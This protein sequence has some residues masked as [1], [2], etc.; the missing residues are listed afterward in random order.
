MDA[1]EAVSSAGVSAVLEIQGLQKTY[2]TLLRGQRVALDGLDMVVERGDVHG[3][4]GPNGSGKST[5]LKILL[6]LVQ[7]DGGHMR[8]LGEPVPARLAA[9][10]PKVGAIVESP[11]FFKNFSGRRTLR[12]LAQAGG[13]P[14]ERVEAALEQVGMRARAGDRVKSYSLGMRQRLAVAS[15]LLKSP[16][17][18]I[19]D[20]PANGLDPA[21]IREMRDLL[22]SLA[23][24]GTTVIIS[25]H[26]LA[27]IQQ[28]CDS[29]TIISRGRRVASGA[30][31][32]VLAASDDRGEY[33]VRVK[34]LQKAAGIIA[35]SG[36]PVTVAADHF[37]VGDL[38][39]PAWITET[40]AAHQLW[41]SEL[42]P[43]AD[44]EDAFL[45][46]TGTAPQRGTFRQ[47]DDADWGK[48]APNQ[49]V[50]ADIEVDKA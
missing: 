45:R 39:D 15:A 44:L 10:A 12:L 5:T 43:L 35:E 20:E 2:Q 9:V 26:I 8:M 18:L 3:F 7:A 46:L 22:R 47:V 40:L 4:L 32:D 6:G 17:L 30:V 21:G 25:S 11:E 42:T 13:V 23:D 31:A 49:P 33:K 50:P 27:E 19:L 14:A 28:I 16:E 38:A 24:G 1:G 29:V 37:V 48:P 41:V 36:L 34:D